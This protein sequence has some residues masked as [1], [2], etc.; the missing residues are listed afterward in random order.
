MGTSERQIQNNPRNTRKI[1]KV[2][3]F[4]RVISRIVL[5]CVYSHLG[6]AADIP[7]LLDAKL[8]SPHV[9]PALKIRKLLSPTPY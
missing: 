6:S 5:C 8:N 9:K 1:K 2:L 7:E 4:V 3:V